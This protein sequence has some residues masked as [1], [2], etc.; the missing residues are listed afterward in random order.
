MAK[1]F[2]VTSWNI[3]AINNNPWEY[4]I[5]YDENPKYVKLM[6]DIERFIENPQEKD[7]PVSKVFTED[8]FSKLMECM[9]NENWEGL[10]KVEEYWNNEYKNRKIISEFLKDKTIGAKRLT[11]MPDRVTNTISLAEPQ[12]ELLCRPTVINVYEGD[13]STMDIW[14]SSWIK[15]V[16]EDETNMKGKDGTLQTKK[17]SKLFPKI[18]KAKYPAISEDEESVSIPLQVLC[19][20]IFDSILLHMLLEVSG[21]DWIEIKKQLCTQLNKNKTPRTCE[22]LNS[23]YSNS[24]I[25]ALQ[26]CGAVFFDQLQK[27]EQMSE[28]FSFHAPANLDRSRDQ[29]SVLLL[30]KKFDSSS[31]VE[32]TDDVLSELGK[33]EKKAPI[34]AGDLFVI[35]ASE[36]EEEEGAR[37]FLI[38]SFHGDTNGL[39][40]IPVVEA[41]NTVYQD[42]YTS[43]HSLIFCLDANTYEKP[44]SSQQG[45]VEFAE[46]YV[47]LGLSSCFGDKPNPSNYTTFNARTY[48]QA[49][50]NKACKS[51]EKTKGDI[52]PKD[53]ILF[54]KKTMSAG[55]WIK[56]NTGN[57]E[58]KE[59]IVFPTLTFPSDHGVLSAVLNHQ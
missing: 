47:S 52:N 15:F 54:D 9:K 3:A 19:L 43:T 40:T 53:F 30:S 49:Q 36:T 7:V 28:K 45:V 22:I 33:R 48:L 44:T 17:I 1:E 2:L 35:V 34:V 27:Y 32:I 58:Y 23:Q 41:I 42:K 31:V 57:K 51:S 16:F 20:A 38:A 24:D 46:N 8:M 18:A 50:L 14:F 56:D 59:N 26:E 4:W 21:N 37:K 10:D 55:K 6:E 29:N 12:G 5:T 11:S 25:I 13:M 39:A